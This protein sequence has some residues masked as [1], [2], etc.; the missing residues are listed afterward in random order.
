[1]K[2]IVI[3]SV[4]AGI[5]AAERLG[6]E[7]DITVYE[8]GS[9]YSCGC[10]GLPHFLAHPEDSLGEA[11]ASKEAQ[12]REKHITGFRQHEV[13]Q[14]DA[15]RREITVCD[16]ETGRVFTDSYDQL[17]LATGG[18]YTMPQVP[19]GDK[20]GVHTLRTVDDVIFLREYIKTPYVRDIVILGAGIGG[21]EIAKAFLARG[22][23]VRIID[24][25]S[26]FLPDFDP[27]VAELIARSL[28]A[29]GVE[30]NLG[31]TVKAFTGR[32]YVETVQTGRGSYPCDLC[33]VASRV[34]PGTQLLSGTGVQTDAEGWVL[35]DRN[36]ATSVPGIYATGE[37]AR[38]REGKPGTESLHVGCLEVARTGLTEE[39]AKK[40]GGQVRSVTVT[41]HDRPGIVPNPHSVSIKLVLDGSG[42]ILGAQ[43]WGEKNVV[44]R[45]NA[46]AVAVAAGM[47]AAQLSEV[48]F[49]Y[50]SAVYGVWDP[51]Q[52]ACDAAGV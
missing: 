29:Q 46:I 43:G 12:M 33:V 39:A 3:G 8:K 36:L 23:H 30:L 19:G 52:K 45:I 31:E 2:T 28:T 5:S 40:K 44:S 1:M 21:L 14:I 17:I 24:P 16:L 15:A 50:S 6:A 26:R 4:S 49:L 9:F 42:R 48:D 37:C 25:E 27:E 18:S 32:T 34:R 20:M 47:T 10:Y 22:R 7:R 38:L 41:G 11:I 35:I 13:R 51:I